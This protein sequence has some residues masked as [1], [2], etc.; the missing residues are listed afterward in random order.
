M[1]Q[2]RATNPTRRKEQR[3]HMSLFTF[4]LD[5]AMLQAFALHQVID[6]RPNVL[7]FVSFK[8]SIC[9]SLVLPLR[10]QRK[11]CK[12]SEKEN[13]NLMESVVGTVGDS[14]GHL[15]I[16]T[17][18]KTGIHCHFCLLRGVKRKTIYG[19]TKC[20]RGFHVNCYTAVHFQGALKS[21]TAAFADMILST[22]RPLPRGMSKKSK[23]VGDISTLTL[24]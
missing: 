20:G 22:E 1:D 17:I 13:S 3:L 21:D 19:C 10:S 4:V 14:D 16:E 6:A 12:S 5:L 15:L 18:N 7:D 9:E 8:R 24:T 11:H 23:Y 2:R